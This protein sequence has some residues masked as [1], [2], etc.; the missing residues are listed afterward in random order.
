MLSSMRNYAAQI[1]VPRDGPS[2]IALP[3]YAG[4]G[5]SLVHAYV[6]MGIPAL[7]LPRFNPSRVLCAIE[8]EGV[9]HTFLVPAALSA[10]A[11][12]QSSQ[13]ANIASL[14]LIGYGGQTAPAALLEEARQALGCDFY[15]AFGATE[16]GG[17][18]TFLQPEEHVDETGH[19]VAERVRSC[20][21]AAAHVELRIVA[22]DGSPAP[23]NTRGELA[24][25]SPSN[26]KG[27]L[28]Q[29]EETRAV[30]RGEWVFTG[31]IAY[32]EPDGFY[33]IVDR[34]KEIIRS[35]SMSVSPSEVEAV[36]MT[37]PDVA[38]AAVVGVPDDRWG[39]AVWAAVVPVKDRKLDEEA[40]MKFAR[41]RLAK[42]KLPKIIRIVDSIPTSPTGKVLRRV[43]RDSF[44]E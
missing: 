26:F 7:I 17:F 38:S 2:L 4:I 40:L 13:R 18:C 8:E 34:K 24:V 15:Q 30:L 20:G 16:V 6:I 44:M 11:K 43:I 21:R 14:S 19:F 37:Y 33:Y 1:A 42:Y 31:D 27:Y 35:G 28:N 3:L 12:E 25:K 5:F 23:N 10:L 36:L 32:K 41:A 39:E 29:E 9:R 22:D